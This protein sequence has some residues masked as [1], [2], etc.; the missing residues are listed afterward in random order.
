MPIMVKVCMYVCVCDGKN[1]SSFYS[2]SAV[3]LS[4]LYSS[5]CSN[6][7]SFSSSHWFFNFKHVSILCFFFYSPV[8]AICGVWISGSFLLSRRKLWRW[9]GNLSLFFRFLSVKVLLLW[10]AIVVAVGGGRVGRC[11]C[12]KS[13]LCWMFGVGVWMAGTSSAME[14]SESFACWSCQNATM[15]VPC[16]SLLLSEWVGGSDLFQKERKKWIS[17]YHYCLGWSWREQ[18]CQMCPNRSFFCFWSMIVNANTLR[19]VQKMQKRNWEPGCWL[20]VIGVKR[21]TFKNRGSAYTDK[22]VMIRFHFLSLSLS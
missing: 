10:C 19:K 5:C 9:E 2:W 8:C 11:D 15:S 18:N 22:A 12:P 20:Q 6:Q 7:F 17:L 21:N 4:G 3:Q 1:V 16:P 14:M 13:Q